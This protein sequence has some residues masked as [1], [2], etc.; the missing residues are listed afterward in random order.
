MWR[1]CV[2]RCAVCI[3]LAGCGSIQASEAR[4]DWLHGAE[5]LP[6]GDGAF[7][8]DWMRRLATPFSG[9]Y[10]PV[11]AA[12]PHADEATD[13]VYVG[14]SSGDFL[15]LAGNGA[16]V[17]RVPLGASVDAEPTTDAAAADVFVGTLDGELLAISTDTG[18]IRWRA[19]I[20]GG[21]RRNAVLSADAVYVVT[22]RDTVVSVARATGDVLWTYARDRSEGTALAGRAGLAEYG[23][24][25]LTGFSDGAVV[26]LSKADGQ[27]VWERDTALDAEELAEGATRFL[28]VDTTPVVAG[29]TVYA[30]SI[31]AGLYGLDVRNGSVRWHR[32]DLTGVTSLASTSVG[33]VIA[34]AE[35]GVELLE[36]DS[37]D[38]VWSRPAARGAPVHVVPVGGHTLLVSESRGGL[39]ALRLATG[40][41]RARVDFGSG[42]SSR[43]FV[44][45]DRAFAVSN[46]GA[47]LALSMR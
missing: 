42:F 22:D 36:L 8:V 33:L 32:A 29:D 5:R 20:G 4:F 17:F 25:V 24:T 41:E 18:D 38:V 6:V 15:A 27:V 45:G 26:A 34:S 11:E 21:V 3:A 13:R 43:P 12:G 44:A 19:A 35:R 46:G 10:T 2:A 30:A 47:L 9:T 7:R 16:L 14:S 31:A 1:R 28:D 39:V 23:D 37:M 40:T